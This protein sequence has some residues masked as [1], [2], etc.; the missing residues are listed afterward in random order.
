MS[1]T[2][3]FAHRKLQRCIKSS[4]TI[5]EEFTYLKNIF[6]AK[7]LKFAVLKGHRFHSGYGFTVQVIL[8]A[9][10]RNRAFKIQA[11]LPGNH[12]LANGDIGVTSLLIL[13]H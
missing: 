4:V 7:L 3:S 8:V 5:L 6:L 9:S 1:E 10:T 2:D 11:W 12:K 13:T